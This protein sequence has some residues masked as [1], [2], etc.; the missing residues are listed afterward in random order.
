MLGWAFGIKI[1]IFCLGAIEVKIP[2][3]L[4]L[5]HLALF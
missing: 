3:K 2:K 4:R 1:C 5:L